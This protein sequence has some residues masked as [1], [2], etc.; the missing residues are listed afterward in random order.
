MKRTPRTLLLPA[1]V[2][3]LLILF[4]TSQGFAQSRDGMFRSVRLERTA[5][6]GNCP[7]YTVEIADD[8]TI[9]YQGIESVATTG[10]HQSQATSESMGSLVEALRR[11]RFFR[12]QSRVKGRRGCE[13]F[14]SDYP[15]ILIRVVT[16]Q[17]AKT[18]S[19]YMGC[20]GSRG[21]QAI[22]KL[23]DQIDHVANTSQWTR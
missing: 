1:L 22:D 11:V 5:C 6:F 19:F 4:A 9:H 20:A 13:T 7:V 3:A 17:H 10:E 8:G 23:A 2:G 14:R 16:Q 18:V 12:M 21:R 15:S